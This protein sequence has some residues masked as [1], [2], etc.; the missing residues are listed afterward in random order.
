V[1]HLIRRSRPLS[2]VTTPSRAGWPSFREAT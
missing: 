2:P 1:D